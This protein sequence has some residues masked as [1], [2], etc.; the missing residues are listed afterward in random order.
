[1]FTAVSSMPRKCLPPSTRSIN[2][3]GLE[4]KSSQVA[5]SSLWLDLLLFIPKAGLRLSYSALRTWYHRFPSAYRASTQAP[6]CFTHLG[7]T[8]FV[9]RFLYL[10]AAVVISAN[11][12]PALVKPVCTNSALKY[13]L[14][15]FNIQFY[16]FQHA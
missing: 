5:G 13:F 2:T 3:Y 6:P 8:F 15:Y 11:F 1:M 16:E 10:P 9:Q 7:L 14:I 4:L 12:N